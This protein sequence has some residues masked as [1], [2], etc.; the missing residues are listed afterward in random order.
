MI[1]KLQPAQISMRWEAI[2]YSY[3]QANRIPEDLQSDSA[4]KLLENLMCGKFECWIIFEDTEEGRQAYAIG[5]S[6]ILR[7]TV[8]GYDYME[9]G[10][11][12]GLRRMPDELAIDSMNKVKEFARA[13]GCKILT[14]HTSH[15]RIQELLRLVDFQEAYTTYTFDL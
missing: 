12:Y 10:T 13:N 8:R 3:I 2:K 4:I 1:V 6:S 11:F 5:I 7:N 15:A 9:L 14:V